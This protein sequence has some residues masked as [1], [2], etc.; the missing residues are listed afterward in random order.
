MNRYSNWGEHWSPST[1]LLSL[2]PLIAANKSDLI[3]MNPLSLFGKRITQKDVSICGAICDHLFIH[4]ITINMNTVDISAHALQ[5]G[6]DEMP[7]QDG[8]TMVIIQS[9]GHPVTCKQLTCTQFKIKPKMDVIVQNNFCVRLNEFWRFFTFHK[10]RFK[11]FPIT[12]I[13]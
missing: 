8:I 7:K 4:S 2:K 12:C 10:T 5:L 9:I 11:H 1:L 3:Y 13:Q 6:S